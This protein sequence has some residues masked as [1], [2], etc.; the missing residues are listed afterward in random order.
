M[1]NNRVFL[2]PDPI[3]TQIAFNGSGINNSLI[4]GNYVDGA[5]CAVYG[6]TD[7]CSNMMVTHNFFKNCCVGVSYS[8]ANRYNLTFDFNNISL[9]PA[10]FV[11]V[12]FNFWPSTVAGTLTNIIIFGNTISLSGSS[13]SS[14]LALAA[15][16]LTGL[17]F[18]NNAVDSVIAGNQAANPSDF[19]D[20]TNLSMY[21]NTDLFGNY[22]QSLNIPMVG[23]VEVSSLGLNLL[24]SADASSALTNLGLP[25]NPATVIT[26]NQPGVTL[27]GTFNGNGSGLTNLAAANIAG[28]VSTGSLPYFL[29]AGSVNL[30]FASGATITF[31]TPVPNTNY[32]ATVTI[33]DSGGIPTTFTSETTNGFT[34]SFSPKSGVDGTLNYTAVENQ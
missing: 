30:S 2:T 33:S 3:G 23:G 15:T 34:V 26:N 7:G 27:N 4:E 9:T 8:S 19:T 13:S 21:N 14:I 12:A 5:D 16:N 28:T 29:R 20:V 10:P 32:A 22:L 24:S 1:R 6:D 25:S 31:S 11:S 18:A 17:V